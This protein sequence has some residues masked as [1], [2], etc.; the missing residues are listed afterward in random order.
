M[1]TKKPV[2]LL[3]HAAFHRPIHYESVLSTLRDRG[4]TVVAPELPTTGDDPSLTYADD[5]A[6]LERVL[7]PLFERG[8]EVV[9]VAHD[10]GALPASHCI[11]GESVAERRECGLAGGIRHYVNVCGLSYS[12]RGRDIVGKRNEFPLQEYHDV[13]VSIC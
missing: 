8:R 3:V 13:D 7:Q 2:I 1:E 11:E 10:F 5:I 9:M 6:V 4:F 12:E